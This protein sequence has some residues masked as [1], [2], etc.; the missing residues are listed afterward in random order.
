MDSRLFHFIKKEFIQLIRDPR[1]LYVAILA[2]VIQLILLGYVASVD[3]KHVSTAVFDQDKS[4]YSRAYVASFK[5]SGYFDINYY[6]DNDE[7][8]VNLLDSGRAKLVLHL[9]PDFG[10][11]S[12]RGEPVSVQAILDGEN[13]STA[14]IISGYINQINFQQARLPDL[15]GLETRVW[16]N[17]EMKSVNFMVPAIFALILTIISMLLTA[18]SIVKEK[19]RGTMEQLIVTPLKPHELIL[20]K[21]LPFTIVAFLD[22]TLVFLIATL[23]FKVPMHGSVALLFILGA[24]FL[25]TGLGLGVFISTISHNQRQAMMSALFVIIPSMILSGFIFPIANMPKAIQALTYLIPV[26]YFLSIVR[27]IFLKGIGMKYLWPDVWPL[28]LFGAVILSL[29]IIRFRKKL[30]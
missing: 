1:M 14:T 5:N 21:L 26:R 29:S 27:G 2:P 4:V 24:I 15:F 19:E 23:W 25:T 13:S 3:I 16:Y 10:R 17:P 7:Q 8:V 30:E 6:V 28:A 22:I 9:P 20:G 12:V 11:K 18:F